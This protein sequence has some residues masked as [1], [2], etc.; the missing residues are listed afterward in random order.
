MDSSGQ[1]LAVVCSIIELGRRLDLTLVAEGVEEV[2][3]RQRL[4]ELGCGCGQGSLFGWPP[5]S[6]DALLAAL[7]RGCDG[8]PGA[9]AGRLHADATVVRLPRQAERTEASLGQQ[10]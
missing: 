8:V 9:L 7:R 4:W 3:Q 1:A 2:G 10:A 6:S 5:L